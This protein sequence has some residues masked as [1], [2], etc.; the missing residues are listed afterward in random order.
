MGVLKI[1]F[2]N[3]DFEKLFLRI[4]VLKINSE[5]GIFKKL[6]LEIG[7]LENYLK[8]EVLKIIKVLKVKVLKIKLKNWNFEKIN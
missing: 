2:E 5:N 8:M 6:N 7:T 3:W 1:K 4:R